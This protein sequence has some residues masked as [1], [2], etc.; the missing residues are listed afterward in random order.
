MPTVDIPYERQHD[1]SSD[2]MCG[3]ASLCMIYRSFQLEC[4]QDQVWQ[5]IAKKDVRGAARART[6]VLAQNALSRG[7][8]ALVLQA[9]IPWKA[10]ERCAAV[11]ARV[12]VNHRLDKESTFGHYSVLL[13][14][15]E[16]QLF[17]H[18]P[19]EGPHRRLGREEF[20]ELWRPNRPSSEITGGV[21]VALTD[22]PESFAGCSV[23]GLTLPESIICPNCDEP[24]VLQ[25]AAVLGC[26]DNS[27]P[28]R[29]WQCL[30]CPK[31][32]M[33]VRRLEEDSVAADP[34]RMK[35]RRPVA[36]PAAIVENQPDSSSASP[37]M[38]PIPSPTE[39][40]PPAPAAIAPKQKEGITMLEK[41][42]AKKADA[43]K[44]EL[45]VNG[46]ALG[47]RLLIELGI[48]DGDKNNRGGEDK[49]VW[50]DL[51]GWEG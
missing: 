11:G 18:D 45:K 14:I 33:A 43:E 42:D 39:V 48:L 34:L 36:K 12:I 25:P 51:D 37:A 9:K 47:R 4:G 22:R 24:I 6:Y 8:A 41:N 5:D 31:C 1:G 40:P 32:D 21:L 38:K 27:C 35:G 50:E 2:R 20:L 28:E 29:T 49:D 15:D 7:V 17:L 30:F 44:K 19:K 10:L 3:A 26:R 16:E 46:N 23:C 13:D